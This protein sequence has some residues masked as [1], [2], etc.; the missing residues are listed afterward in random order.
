M[1]TKSGGTDDGPQMRGLWSDFESNRWPQLAT[2]TLPIPSLVREVG[3]S[4]HNDLAFMDQKRLWSTWGQV[5]HNVENTSLVLSQHG[6][7][8][9]DIVSVQLPNWR[10]AAIVML[11][12][13]RLGAIVNPITPI[14]R[15]GEL[16]TIFRMAQ[17]THVVCPVMYG[18]VD[19]VAM[20]N[21][22]LTEA[23]LESTIITVSQDPQLN[24]CL[25]PGSGATRELPPLES[26]RAEDLCLLM[27][28]SGTTGKPK[29]VLHSHQTL[30]Y[31]TW[32]IIE[33]FQL[34]QPRVF[35]PSPMTHITG[36]LYGILLPILSRGSSVLQDRWNATEAVQLIEDERCNF[37][38]G[39]TPFLSGLVKEYESIR[40]TSNLTN[41]VCGGADVP[42]AL[43][44]RAQDAMGTTAVRAYG[45][46]E[47]PTLT[48]GQ[49]TDS[50]KLRCA[51]DGRLIGHSQARLSDSHGNVGDLEVRGPEMFLG[52]LDPSDN[53]ESFTKDGWFRTGDIARL[54]GDRVE[55]LGRRKDIIVRG[56][57][58]F[59]PMEI[60]NL[61]LGLSSVADIAI[62]GVPDDQLGERACAMIVP[63]GDPPTLHDLR[64]FLDTKNVA[65][66]KAPEH[67]LLC[68]ELDRTAS[69]KIQKFRLK[70]KA[71]DRLNAGEGESR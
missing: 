47:L 57:E 39:A 67:L 25:S 9:G 32:S 24:S 12:I 19:Y 13:W 37:S 58:N 44:S 51:D 23:G 27:F 70:Q 50:L 55:I 53:D 1:S 7:G 17:P 5:D 28:T 20:T 21:Q 18:E 56:G 6:V 26:L 14:Y 69:G 41:F 68:N 52:Y 54:E 36:L 38:I 62:V 60:E 34:S 15:T 3:Q 43:I 66:Q 42:P 4:N 65:R 22:A 61:L 49:P 71:I 2:F 29:G 8:R 16:Q 46:T 31:E 59:S 30:L 63:S 35:M 45:L 64:T 48:C 40:Q 10:E 11:A 33:H